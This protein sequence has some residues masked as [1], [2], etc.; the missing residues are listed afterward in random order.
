[1]IGN[2]V[3][4]ITSKRIQNDVG[5]STNKYE[6][7][8]LKGTVIGVSFFR[9]KISVVDKSGKIHTPKKYFHWKFDAEK[10]LGDDD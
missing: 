4:F 1:M 5:E 3:Y 8:I 2:N 6:S 7:E 10:H 9:T